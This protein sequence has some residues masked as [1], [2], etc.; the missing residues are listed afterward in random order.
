MRGSTSLTLFNLE[1]DK[2]I[3]RKGKKKR[4][5]VKKKKEERFNFFLGSNQA[6]KN[7]LDS[8]LKLI[9][10]IKLCRN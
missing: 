10:L 5:E 3:G 8:I 6:T 1:K 7:I 4:K 9:H 2:H